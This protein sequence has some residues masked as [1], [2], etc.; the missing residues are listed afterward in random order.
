MTIVLYKENEEGWGG[1]GSGRKFCVKEEEE[2]LLLESLSEKGDDQLNDLQKRD[3]SVQFHT[4]S[5]EHKCGHLKDCFNLEDRVPSK[6]REE[7]KEIH[8][9]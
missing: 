7:E 4:T 9:D 3:A 2:N 5:N 6:T 1:V 8:D